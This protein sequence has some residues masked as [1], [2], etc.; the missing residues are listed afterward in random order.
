MVIYIDIWTDVNFIKTVRQEE[1]KQS[2]GGCDML[3]NG[4]SVMMD[5]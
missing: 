3:T 1:G 2:V 4:I 5:C